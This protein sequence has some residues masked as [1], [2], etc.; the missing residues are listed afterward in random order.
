MVM[1]H[2]CNAMLQCNQ[3]TFDLG[4]ICL[5]SSSPTANAKRYEGMGTSCLNLKVWVGAPS[6]EGLGLF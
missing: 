6:A 1:F 4:P 3:L 2:V 5:Y